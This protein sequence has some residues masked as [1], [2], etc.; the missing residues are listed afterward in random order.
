MAVQIISNQH[1]KHG[2]GESRI[3]N[4]KKEKHQEGLESGKSLLKE[5]VDFSFAPENALIKMG[6]N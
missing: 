6:T 4:V 1:K 2:R 3:R 5:K